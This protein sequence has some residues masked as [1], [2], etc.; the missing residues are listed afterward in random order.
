MILD[1]NEINHRFFNDL[2][3]YYGGKGIPAVS[4]SVRQFLSDEKEEE[5][6]NME[7]IDFT[8]LEMDAYDPEEVDFSFLEKPTGAPP[9]LIAITKRPV[10][11]SRKKWKISNVVIG[12]RN[13]YS[14]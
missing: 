4:S 14:A 10:L 9:P 12:P 2:F 11:D 6:V 13:C 3:R 7:E 8:E 5:E 1:E